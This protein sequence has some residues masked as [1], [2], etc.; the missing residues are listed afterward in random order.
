MCVCDVQSDGSVIVKVP[1]CQQ[2]SR[3]RSKHALLDLL[4]VGR[5]SK[6]VSAST[7]VTS[8]PSTASASTA[9]ASTVSAS[10]ASQEHVETTAH[11]S[12]HNSLQIRARRRSNS[13]AIVSSESTATPMSQLLATNTT[14]IGP[15]QFLQLVYRTSTAYHADTA[16]T[17]CRRRVSFTYLLLSTD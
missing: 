3:A 15:D 9:S 2:T 7:E 10:S 16:H 11:C 12:A 4:R 17:L 6:T 1:D 14:R 13:V 8:T 5:G